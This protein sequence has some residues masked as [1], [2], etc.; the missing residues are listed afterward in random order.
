MTIDHFLDASGLM[1]PL[2]LLRAKLILN[3]MATGE[4]LQVTATDAG[5]VK[6]FAEFTRLTGH[7]LL[8]S[9]QDGESFIY[10]IEK[11]AV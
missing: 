10:L 3:K 2:P 11:A 5:S 7:H 9:E 6:D 8:R 4:T 1:C